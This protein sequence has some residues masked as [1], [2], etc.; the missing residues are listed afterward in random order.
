[1]PSNELFNLQ[2]ALKALSRRADVHGREG[3][4]VLMAPM[5]L[6]RKDIFDFLLGQGA[7]PGDG[8]KFNALFREAVCGQNAVIAEWLFKQGAC[9]QCRAD[10]EHLSHAGRLPE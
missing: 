1:M 9:Q 5:A 8:E 4:R 7:V 6:G 10:G 3:R 2:Q